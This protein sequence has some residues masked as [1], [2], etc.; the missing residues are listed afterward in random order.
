MNAFCMSASNQDGA[1]GNYFA[2]WQRYRI[3]AGQ[4]RVP[5]PGCW[6]IIDENCHAAGD[7]A[8][9]VCRWVYKG[10]TRRDMGGEVSRGTIEGGSLFVLDQH[11]T[12][13]A[14]VDHAAEGQPR[15]RRRWNGS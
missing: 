10:S 1:C 4:S 3:V 9:F 2:D 13:Q 11:I 14:I 5:C 12:S 8:P 15:Q 6:L 7:N